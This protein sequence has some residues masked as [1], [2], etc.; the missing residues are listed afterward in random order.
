V[1]GVGGLAPSA[2]GVEALE[3]AAGAATV[4][5]FEFDVGPGLRPGP[6]AGGREV[7]VGFGEDRADPRVA[8]KN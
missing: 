6:A 4:V 7:C 8:C 5:E 3:A 1:T 2:E